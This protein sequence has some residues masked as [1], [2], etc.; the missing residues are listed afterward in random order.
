MGVGNPSDNRFQVFFE[1]ERYLSLKNLLYNY[2][3]RKA[4][5]N[6]AIPDRDRRLVLEV[7][8][9]VS[10]M[11]TQ[12]EKL[13]FSDRSLTALHTLKRRLKNGFFVVADGTALPFKSGIFFHVVC[14]EV[15]EH[16]HDDVS[17]FN[18]LSRVTR[19]AGALVLTF[20]HRM[21]YF[22]LDDRFV[23]HYRRYESG[24]IVAMAANTG[25]EVRMVRKV[26]GPLEKGFAILL[27]CL[28]S[29]V[30]KSGISTGGG[31]SGIQESGILHWMVKWSNR[32]LALL[33]AI[34]AEIM[35]ECLSTVLLMT[36]RKND[37]AH[38]ILKD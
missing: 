16:I 26:L 28:Y 34:D 35:P 29:A 10:P 14:S 18:E 24:D 21:A 37:T 20:P 27:I 22:S 13:V 17:V 19:S 12:G 7:G 25:L 38:H 4:A 1:D 11:I 15:I 32:V 31:A 8:S 2:R 3:L 6:A 9:G 23:H 5:V 33:V 30:S 36:F